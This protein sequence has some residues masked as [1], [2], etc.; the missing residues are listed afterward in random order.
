MDKLKALHI[1]L[2]LELLL[3]GAKDKTIV[4]STLSLAKR[5]EKSQQAASYHLM[6]LES[7]G[8]IE[9]VKLGQKNGIKITSKGIDGITKIYLQLKG[10]LEEIPTT[11]ELRGELFS[12]IGEGAY[13]VSLYGYRKQFFR[14]LGFD[15]Y[16]GTLNVS[17]KT[18]SDRRFRRD[19]EQYQGIYLEGFQDEN[20]TYGG[21]WCFKVILND[22]VEG[23]LLISERTHYDDSVLEIISPIYIRKKLNL[24]DGDL[25]RVRIYIPTAIKSS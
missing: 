15:P 18:L 8:L 25:I 5:I 11:I 24:R 17:L 10:A 12:G 7:N 14:K 21:V 9:R 13:Y 1:P 20:R 22:V 23:A 19:L 6:E 4:I 2:I 3:L 16:P